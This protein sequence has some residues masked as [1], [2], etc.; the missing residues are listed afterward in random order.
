MP[1]ASARCRRPNARMMAARVLR[2][3]PIMPKRILIVRLLRSSP[4]AP[5]LGQIIV[6]YGGLQCAGVSRR[7]YGFR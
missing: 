2:R 6:W 5:L 1:P 3:P 7:R 4:F